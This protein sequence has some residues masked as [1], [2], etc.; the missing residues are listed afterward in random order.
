MIL[1]ILHLRPIPDFYFKERCL[2]LTTKQVILIPTVHISAVVY[3]TVNGHVRL[4]YTLRDAL[5]GRRRDVV[6]YCETCKSVS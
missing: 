6:L 5:C 1:S 4:K 3:L 2:L